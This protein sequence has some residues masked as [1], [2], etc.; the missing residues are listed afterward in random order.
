MPAYTISIKDEETS[1]KNKNLFL[2]LLETNQRIIMF[3]S[4]KEPHLFYSF[5][6]LQMLDMFININ[7]VV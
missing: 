3:C 5:I 4:F 7:V 6:L 2:F 1:I